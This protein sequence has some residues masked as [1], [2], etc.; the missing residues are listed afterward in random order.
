MYTKSLKKKEE[1]VDILHYDNALLNSIDIPAIYVCG[2]ANNGEGGKTQIK[3]TERERH[4]W[5]LAKI[6]GRWIPLDA[7][8]G[9][10][11]GILPVSHI[12]QNYFKTTFKITFKGRMR[13]LEPNE[14]IVYHRI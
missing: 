9:I 10:F 4:A 6:E 13:I 3:D 5:T 7:T 2:L 12:F 14:N 1:F 8:W 11:K